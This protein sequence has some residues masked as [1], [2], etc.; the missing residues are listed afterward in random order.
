MNRVE[1][2]SITGKADS[3]SLNP[4]AYLSRARHLGFLQ[5]LYWIP[6]WAAGILGVSGAFG[7]AEDYFVV[8]S[9]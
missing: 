6:P 9:D 8:I 7:A 5:E 1:T 3:G 2:G 4:I